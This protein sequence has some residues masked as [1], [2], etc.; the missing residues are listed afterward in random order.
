MLGP[1]D[2]D[3]IRRLE[4]SLDGGIY[5]SGSGTLVR[6]LLADGLIDELHLF[7]YPV[8]LGPGQR[9]FAPDAPSG[10]WA[11]GTCETYDNGVIYLRYRAK[12]SAASMA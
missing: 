3:R 11:L 8:T 9:L 2:A 1:Y 5:M 7:V 6:A 4:Q 12:P 10:T